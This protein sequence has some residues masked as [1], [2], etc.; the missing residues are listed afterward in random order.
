[1]DLV[2]R[3]LRLATPEQGLRHAVLSTLQPVV[4]REELAYTVIWWRRTTPPEL[5]HRVDRDAVAKHGQKRA[6]YTG[7]GYQILALCIVH[8]LAALIPVGTTVVGR[9][10]VPSVRLVI[11]SIYNISY[12]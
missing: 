5:W 4:G 1:M 6:E 12:E 3:N 11:E 10:I 8:N 2:N 7:M 9:V